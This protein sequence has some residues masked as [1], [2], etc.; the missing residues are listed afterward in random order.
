MPSRAP[1]FVTASEAATTARRAASSS[2]RPEARPAAS[3]P[4]SV[5]PAP[6]VSTASTVSAG[7]VVTEPAVSRR[8]PAAPRLTRSADDT[9]ADRRA[10]TAPATSAPAVSPARDASSPSFGVT[11]SAAARIAAVRP[12]AGAGLRIVVAPAARAAARASRTD[13]VGIS[14]P[15]RTT[16][17][18]FDRQVVEGLADLR[19][20]HRPV[21]PGRDRDAVLALG[22]DQDQGDAGRLGRPGSPARRAPRPRP[23]GPPRACSPNASSPTAPTNDGAGT[24]PGGRHGLVAA[25][26]AVMLGEPAADDG[27]AGRRQV[28]RR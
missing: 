7:S 18:A 2:D 13:S 16:S 20:R 12:V 6:T 19:R 21:R 5:S 10:A 9:P 27:L 22:V 4:L 24:Q 15:T 3:A 28:R 8:A 17:P 11:M 25:L 23:P 14:W 26:P 1:A